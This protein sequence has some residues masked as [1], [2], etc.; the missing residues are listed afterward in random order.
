MSVTITVPLVQSASMS[1]NPANINTAVSL[2]VQVIEQSIV[3]N[4]IYPYSGQNNIFSG[5]VMY[6]VD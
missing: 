1:P 6:L 4:E 2:V 5:E 3:L